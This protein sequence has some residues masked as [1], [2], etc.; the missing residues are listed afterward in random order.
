MKCPVGDVIDDRIAG[1]VTE[2]ISLF[3]GATLASDHD[4]DFDLP[5]NLVGA[6][7]G[8]LHRVAGMRKRRRG[9]LHKDVWKRLGA[10][11]RAAAPLFDVL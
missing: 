1:H 9:R 11:L 3:D 7:T 6:D 10:F 5:V 4:A 2:C 8:D